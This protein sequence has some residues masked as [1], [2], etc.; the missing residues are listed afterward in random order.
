[1]FGSAL[2]VELVGG[3]TD[4]HERGTAGGAFVVRGGVSDGSEVKT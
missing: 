2:R 1:M 4:A 3:Q